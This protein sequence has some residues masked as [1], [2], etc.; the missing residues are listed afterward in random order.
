MW[1]ICGLVWWVS[2]GLCFTVLSLWFDGIFT[3]KLYNFLF[4]Y[5]SIHM[6]SR[7]HSRDAEVVVRVA[8]RRLVTDAG[9][10]GTRAISQPITHFLPQPT[11]HSFA[12]WC[13]RCVP[14]WRCRRLISP[15]FPSEFVSFSVKATATPILCSFFNFYRR[16]LFKTIFSLMILVDKYRLIT[17]ESNKRDFN[18]LTVGRQKGKI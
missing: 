14:V 12:D 18:M 7:V 9:Q 3:S 1:C 8:S 11:R 13:S 4:N 15:V 5:F 16:I 17:I 10:L 6:L 2:M